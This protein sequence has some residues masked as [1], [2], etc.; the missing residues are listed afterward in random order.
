[1]QGGFRVIL[2]EGKCIV[3]QHEAALAGCIGAAGK[4]PDAAH[5]RNVFVPDY[6]EQRNRDV[7]FIYVDDRHAGNLRNDRGDA[8]R[9]PYAVID[10]GKR[11]EQGNF[12]K[13]ARY[14]GFVAEKADGKVRFGADNDVACER[15][16]IGVLHAAVGAVEYG[17]RNDKQRE[18]E[19]YEQYY[20]SGASAGKHV[21]QGKT[22]CK[23]VPQ[24]YHSKDKNASYS[25]VSGTVP[26]GLSASAL[27]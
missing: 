10:F 23:H 5:V 25:T 20:D 14:R 16:H 8:L 27:P 24:Y 4:H 9:V 7:F 19:R 18:R 15:V 11:N 13:L 1:M 22:K 17:I 21:P 3:A 12:G 2:D 26:A 6:A